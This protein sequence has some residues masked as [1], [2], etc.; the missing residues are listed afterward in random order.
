MA[1]QCGIVGLPNVGKS[2][3][4]NCLSN[5]KAQAANFPFC[6]IEPNVGV[7]TVPDDRLNK[8]AEL[9]DP[10]R[11]VPTTVEIVDI[12]GLVKGASKGEG[13]GNKFLANIRET[14]AILHVLRCFDDENVTHVDGSVDPV[15]DKEIID[16]E[17][18][19][20]D[21]E[22]IESRIQKVQK[23]AQTGGDK[24]AK[25][26]YEVLVRYREALLQGK[27]ARTV[28]FETKDEQKIAHELFLLTSKPVMYVCNVDEASAVSGNKYVEQV[29]EA[30]KE[31]GAEILIVA[32]KTEADIAELETYEDRR[33]FLQEV[34]LEESGV[35][36]LIRAAYKLLNLETYFTAGKMEVRAWTFHKGWKAPQCA[37]VIHT[38]FEKG[39]IRAEVIK[40]DDFIHYGSEAAVREAG[41]LNVEGKEYVVEDGDIMHF[42]F[43]VK[44]TYL[45]STGLHAPCLFFFITFFTMNYLIIGTGGVGGC[46]AGFLALAGKDVTCIARG[47][48]LEAI[49]RQGLHLK[50]DLKGEHFLPVK[51]CTAEEYQGKADVIL[52][53]VKGYSIDS[54]RPVLERAATPHTLVIP[55]LNVY[56]TGPRIGRLVPS[57]KVLDGCI[58]IV[59][60]VSGEG[61]ISQMGRI[62]RLVFGA[63]PQQ[64]VAPERLER[65]AGEL[66]ECGIKV[67]VSDDINRDTFIKWSF[68]SAMACT[69]AYHDV[70]MGEVQ[71]EGEVRDT[72]VGLSRESAQIGEKLGIAYPGDP[73]AYNLMVIDKLDPHST[74][75]MQKD[76][77]RGHESEIQGLLFDMID[78]GA[79]LHIDMP[80]YRKVAQKFQQP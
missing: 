73:V 4:F 56:G 36:R 55:I 41:K 77:A 76:I 46:I 68:I 45:S 54:I 22:T 14:D 37:G 63:R 62:F 57:V 71:H 34:G 6:T 50:S 17:L 7:I 10:D 38:D 70:P 9:V 59:G 66:R 31:E 51:A 23:Q 19:L 39:F 64:Q 24:V 43:N 75:S 80:V 12:A 11:I 48:H 44:S 67:D 25:Q 32:A 5:A 49:R 35:S 21:L 53:C 15:R 47:K 40:Y 33:M 69:G 60:F 2:T 29:R 20:K 3:L 42:R 27:S 16:T 28:Q 79:Q 58:Y 13:L 8:L 65:I 18:Q 1:L 30:V 78:L 26:T 74:A 61:E 72:F 52:V